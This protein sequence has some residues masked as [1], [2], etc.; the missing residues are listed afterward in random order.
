MAVTASWTIE[1]LAVFCEYCM[2]IEVL[3]GDKYCTDCANDV[4]E[5][6]AARF[7]EQEQCNNG[8]Y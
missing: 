2:V 4:T 1:D 8:W 7:T 3:E 6:L 5:Y